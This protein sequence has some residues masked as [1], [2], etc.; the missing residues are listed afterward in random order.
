M[1]VSV[2]LAYM[3]YLIMVLDCEPF[4]RVHGWKAQTK[5]FDI[6][7]RKHLRRG[8]DPTDLHVSHLMVQ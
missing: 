8:A 6:G 2:C 1:W 7:P 5:I 4:S 3:S